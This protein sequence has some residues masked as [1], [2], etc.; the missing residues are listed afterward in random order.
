MRYTVKTALP[1]EA[2]DAQGNLLPHR[3]L[4]CFQQLA[5]T[6]AEALGLGFEAMLSKNLL[7]VVTQIRY[8]VCAP[9]RPEQ[10]LILE[11]WPLPP[12]RLGYERCY[13]IC[14]ESGRELLRG[15]SNWVVIDTATR[16]LALTDTIYPSED[17]RL[18]KTFED[19]ARRLKDFEAAEAAYTV[20]PGEQHIDNNGHVNNTFYAA[21][22]EEALGS[23]PAAIG[24]FQIDYLHEVLQSQPLTLY[25]AKEDTSDLI[26]GVSGDGERMFA[27]KI[28]YQ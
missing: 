17:F 18:E 7:W 2:F 12:N 16:R 10:P 19:R 1:T 26:K 6:H 28:E 3:V 9:I 24:R 11:T 20:T 22:A 13:R 25:T 14:D 8:Q 4:D 27:C 5:T 21:F 15:N 23:F